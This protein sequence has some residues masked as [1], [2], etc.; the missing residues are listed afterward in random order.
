MQDQYTRHCPQPPVSLTCV[1]C[2][3]VFV[4]KAHLARRGRRFCSSRCV[5][6]HPHP[7]RDIAERFWS[8]VA[9]GEGNDC[10]PWTAAMRHGYGAFGIQENGCVKVL[11]A[12]VMAWILTHGPVPTGTVVRHLVC[13]NPPCCNPAHLALG[14]HQD[15]VD[16]MW[17]KGRARPGRPPTG[18]ANRFAK[19]SDAIIEQVRSLYVPRVTT[20][21]QLSE[22]FG[23]SASH[24]DNI[25]DGH[26]GVAPK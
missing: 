23:I 24:I 21:K 10:W 7:H 2:G 19:Y 14:S 22:R 18:E 11:A 8:H 20:R 6:A 12:H 1:E 25:L 17:K 9:I 13:D 4:V 26:R 16:D 3:K 15:N 5:N